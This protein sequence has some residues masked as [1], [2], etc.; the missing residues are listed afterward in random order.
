MNNDC[1]PGLA[2]YLKMLKQE[3]SS[4]RNFTWP[5]QLFLGVQGFR[6]LNGW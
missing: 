6:C 5:F 4:Q 3:I 1:Q 2:I